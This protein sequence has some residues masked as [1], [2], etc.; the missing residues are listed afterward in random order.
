MDIG[1]A[2][3]ALKMGGRVTRRGWNGKDMFLELQKPDNNSLM[4]LP[5]VFMY[6]AGGDLVPWFCSQVDLL[7]YDWVEVDK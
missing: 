4:T 2:V 6:T 1:H 5:Y 7:A 3:A